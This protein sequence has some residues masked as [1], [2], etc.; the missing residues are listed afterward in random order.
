MGILDAVTFEAEGTR[1][2]VDVQRAFR[3]LYDEKKL[4]DSISYQKA[5]NILYEEVKK[6]RPDISAFRLVGPKF[7]APEMMSSAQAGA[8]DPDVKI[9]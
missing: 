9:E 3:I 5:L 6:E 2:V 7:K 1:A 8:G 4:P